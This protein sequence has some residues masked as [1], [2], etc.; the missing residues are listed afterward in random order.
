MRKILMTGSALIMMSGLAFAQTPAGGQAPTAGMNNTGV[1]GQ[2]PGST[3]GNM[4]PSSPNPNTA[5]PAERQST[6]GKTMHHGA[7]NGGMHHTA[8]RNGMAHHGMMNHGMISHSMGGGMPM[9]ASAAEYLHI[10]QQA[11]MSHNKMRAHDALGRA[12]TDMLTNSYV[13]GSVNGPISTPAI[14]AVRGARKAVEGGDYH[15]AS[16]MIHRAMM[17]M[18]QGMMGRPGMHK[19]GM[20]ASSDMGTPVPGNTG[21]AP[22]GGAMN[23]GGMNNGAMNNG[24]MNHGAMNNG[25]MN[26]GSMPGNAMQGKKDSTMHN[27]MTNSTGSS[28]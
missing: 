26:N 6:M 23:N 14:A 2:M 12:E 24:A 3:S 28:M 13:Q 11:V 4:T 16:M 15:H 20:G 18:H 27:Q 21:M 17:E 19:P 1:T 22:D 5:M 8:M 10:A 7:M 25:A 9:N